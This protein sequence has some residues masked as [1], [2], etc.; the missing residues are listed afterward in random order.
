MQDIF[1]PAKKVVHW[2]FN[3]YQPSSGMLVPL[4]RWCAS[5]L[6]AALLCSSKAG[7][8]LGH[9]C[10]PCTLGVPGLGIR[11]LRSLDRSLIAKESRLWFLSDLATVQVI[12][13][14]NLY[15]IS[16]TFSECL[17]SYN[18]EWVYYWECALYNL[19]SSSYIFIQILYA[20]WC[21][22]INCLW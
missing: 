21:W 8:D 22:F 5:T 16:A 20:I 14:F 2:V 1:W 6:G 7:S 3:Y 17:M 13:P 12:R 15:Q 9:V 19:S 18:K 11:C 4:T 10:L